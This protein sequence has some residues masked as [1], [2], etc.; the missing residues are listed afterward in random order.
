MIATATIRWI[1]GSAVLAA[2]PA[3]APIQAN[4][5]DTLPRIGVLMPVAENLEEDLRR[6]LR[7]LG[8]IEGKTVAIEWH[9]TAG[10][11]EE[12]GSVAEDLVRSK[13]ELIVTWG[14][15]A[16]R[17]VLDTTQTVPIVFCVADPVAMGMFASLAKPGGNAT[18]VAL[19]VPELTA[20]RV[21]LIRQ[22]VPRARRIAYLRNPSNPVA[23]RQFTVAQHAARTWGVDL[24]AL[25]ARD[26]REVHLALQALP[27]EGVDALIV[28]GER[29]FREE[30][31]W[32]ARVVRRAK[33]P[34]IFPWSEGV[35]EGAVMSYAWSP[36]DVARR[37][38]MYI[39]RIRKGA[40]PADLPV[41]QVSDY[42]LVVNLSVAR[43]LGIDVPRSLVLRADEV[44]Q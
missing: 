25:D 29:L 27:Q 44:I 2:G 21:E 33:L 41:E 15:P 38:A 6:S 12:L 28:S 8:Y 14:I 31:V 13:V 1:V 5:P 22:L 9:N 23:T 16:T 30:R 24:L 11:H 20:K 18:G 43:E 19:L 17:A 32:I 10:T 37:L 3:S 40:K 34:T 4:Q 36:K 35:Q 42:Q 7:D 26:T 39:D